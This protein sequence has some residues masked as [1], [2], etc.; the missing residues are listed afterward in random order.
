MQ[1]LNY[2]VP[3]LINKRQVT[4]EQVMRYKISAELK[5]MWLNA[6]SS[7]QIL[8]VGATSA[9]PSG[10]VFDETVTK[11]H[12]AEFKMQLK[13][14]MSIQE[15][16]TILGVDEVTVFALVKQ[17]LLISLSLEG[18]GLRIN[19][20]SFNNFNDSMITCKRIASLKNRPLKQ[21]LALCK[22]LQIP[23]VKIEGAKK[24]L[25]IPRSQLCLFGL[26]DAIL[27]KAAA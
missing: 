26:D 9:L 2:Q 20:E 27:Y 14:T 10:L 16:A 7:R 8:A 17:G 25:W 13:S 19:Q 1:G 22:Q 5:A 6:V 21:I 3:F 18:F 23:I 24:T 12:I 11:S 4:L 15:V